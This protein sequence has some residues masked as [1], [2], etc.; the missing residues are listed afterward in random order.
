MVPSFRI[1][2]PS[3]RRIR[4]MRSRSILCRCIIPSLQFNSLTT[5]L[6]HL[7]PVPRIYFLRASLTK[8]NYHGS[9]NAWRNPHTRLHLRMQALCNHSYLEGPIIMLRIP[10][11]I[12]HQANSADS[13]QF[14]FMVVSKQDL[15][16]WSVSESMKLEYIY[17]YNDCAARASLHSNV[18][19]N[20]IGFGMASIK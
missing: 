14:T 8:L 6:I 20:N 12:Q 16:R 13:P 7:L 1:T 9:H 10:L 19:I 3:L 11:K 4:S 15:I 18:Q 2:L 17:S 5:R